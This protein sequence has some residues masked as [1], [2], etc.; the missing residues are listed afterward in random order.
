MSRGQTWAE[1]E[2][3]TLVDI[4]ADVHISEMLD[5][6][7]KNADVFAV[8][9]DKMRE[10]GFTRSPEQCHLKVKKLR[11]TYMKIRDVLK[12]SGGTS[13]EKKKCIYYDDL[14]NILGSKP[15]ASPVDIVEGT[16]KSSSVCCSVLCPI[17]LLNSTHMANHITHMQI[18]GCLILLLQCSQ[19]LLL[20]GPCLRHPHS[21]S[22][23]R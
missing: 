5:R 18:T 7:H 8:F 4:W 17:L 16:L 23:C 19:T 1:E 15:L 22:L 21:C 20:P 14:D 6:T 12:A 3:R 10:K 9:S 13:D 2:I 11:Q